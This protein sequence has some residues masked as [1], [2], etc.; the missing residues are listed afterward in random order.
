MQKFVKSSPKSL[1][2]VLLDPSCRADACVGCAFSLATL[3]QDE[4]ASCRETTTAR[5]RRG[6]AIVLEAYS[7]ARARNSA[8]DPS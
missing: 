2:W 3:A 4:R 7:R 6:D 1:H 5:M 8:N